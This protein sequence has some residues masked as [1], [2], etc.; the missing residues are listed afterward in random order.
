MARQVLIVG[1]GQFG[2]A[3]AKTLSRRGLEVLAVDVESRRVQ[4]IAPHVSEAMVVD[5]MEEEGLASLAPAERDVCVCAIGDGNREAS[6]LATALLRQLGAPRVVARATDD[7]HARI[8]ARVGA[9]EVVRPELDFA[10]TLSVRLASD[11]VLN[12]VE[13]GGDLA[14]TEVRAPEVLIGQSLRELELRQRYGVIVIAVRTRGSLDV[15]GLP[16]PDRPLEPG[17]VLVIVG[18]DEASDRLVRSR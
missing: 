3:L 16:D 4:E 17:D 1:L 7:L 5:A 6:I 18:S 8:L 15:S 9:H 11:T 2:T 10:K 12:R 14:L 13:L